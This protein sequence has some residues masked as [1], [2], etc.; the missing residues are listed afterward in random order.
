M[1]LFPFADARIA[2]ELSGTRCAGLFTGVAAKAS[3]RVKIGAGI[4]YASGSASHSHAN[5]NLS[6][7]G[8]MQTRCRSDFSTCNPPGK[9]ANNPSFTRTE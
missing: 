4:G 5:R 6:V 1:G 2:I 8:R 9:I 7:R 3:A